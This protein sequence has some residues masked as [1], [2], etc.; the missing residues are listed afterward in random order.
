MFTMRSV[1][2]SINFLGS[3]SSRIS[4]Y[5]VHVLAFGQVTLINGYDDDD[6]DDT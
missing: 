3:Y 2:G 6:D 4:L 5:V 1:H